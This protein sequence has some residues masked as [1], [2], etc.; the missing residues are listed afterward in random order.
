VSAAASGGGH[1]QPRSA[2][3]EPRIRKAQRASSLSVARRRGRQKFQG[4]TPHRRSCR[5][6]RSTRPIWPRSPSGSAA[7]WSG[8]SACS[9]CSTARL[10]ARS[11]PGYRIGAVHR[12]VAPLDRSRLTDRE[13]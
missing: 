10:A 3:F 9:G 5:P 2:A 4:A 6:D 8:G 11:R 12:T 13:G 1:G 7:A